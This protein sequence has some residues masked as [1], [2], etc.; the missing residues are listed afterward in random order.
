MSIQGNRDQKSDAPTYKF[1]TKG[2][3]GT[4]QYG[5]TVFGADATEV[6]VTDGI[7]HKGWVQRTVGT[8]GRNGRTQFEVL[9]VASITGDSTSFTDANTTPV[10]NSTGTADDSVLPD[11][12]E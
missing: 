8:G 3:T 9:S 7:S 4:E 2:E 10:A 11:T 12:D 1:N 6:G 5:N